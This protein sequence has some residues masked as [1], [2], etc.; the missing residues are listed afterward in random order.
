[1]KENIVWS[2]SLLVLLSELPIGNF[3]LVPDVFDRCDINIVNGVPPS[4]A[5][6]PLKAPRV[7][8]NKTG[9]SGISVADLREFG[10]QSVKV[11]NSHSIVENGGDGSHFTTLTSFLNYLETGSVIFLV[12]SYSFIQ[13]P[14]FFHRSTVIMATTQHILLLRPS[15]I[16]R[17]LLV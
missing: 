9:F 5:N 13:K 11:G 10:S 16:Y 14:I 4:L 15:V 6:Y 1:M 7:W 2:L 8:R 17:H 12:I 3:G